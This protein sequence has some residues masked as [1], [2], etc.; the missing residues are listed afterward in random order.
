MVVFF[1]T[2]VLRQFARLACPLT[3]PIMRMNR[4]VADV[5]VKREVRPTP[6]RGESLS[7]A[8]RQVQPQPM[9]VGIC[10][11]RASTLPKA[12]AAFLALEVKGLAIDRRRP[13]LALRREQN[14]FVQ[15]SQDVVS[16]I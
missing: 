9:P 11:R 8:M 6:E 14:E 13:N 7:D 12:D 16:Y 4:C 5:R 3:C 2:A 1:G 15:R 10:L